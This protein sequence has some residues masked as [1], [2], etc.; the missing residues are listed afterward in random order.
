MGEIITQEVPY[1]GKGALLHKKVL[2]T[3][4]GK[5]YTETVLWQNPSP[6]SE[7][8]SG[9][10]TLSDSLSNYKY[11]K[12][13]A[14]AATTNETIWSTIYL[15]DDFKTFAQNST[16]SGCGHIAIMNA[17]NARRSRGLVYVDDTTVNFKVAYEDGNSTLLNTTVI[18]LQIIGIKEG[19]VPSYKTVKDFIYD[20]V[21]NSGLPEIS[22]YTVYNNRVTV[23][24]GKIVA[25]AVTHKVYMYFDFTTN[26]AIGS[27]SD[28]ASLL[29]FT[30]AIVNY[31]PVFT[32]NSRAN[33]IALITDDSSDIPT[34]QF[35]WGYGTSN[36]PYKLFM[37]YGSTVQANEH[38]IIYAEYTYK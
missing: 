27:A 33:N 12:I 2:Y 25:D 22:T 30:S 26:V 36:Y 7:F 9:N 28:W 34:R 37:P 5:G 4:M 17:N 20:K 8:V 23:S 29:T 15:V 10:V 3:G 16:V 13:K 31:T 11:I 32:A 1:T 35:C 6:T 18:P 38:Y 19:I 24:E 21:F 14:R